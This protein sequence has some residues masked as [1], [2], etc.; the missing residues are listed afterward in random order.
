[1][2]HDGFLGNSNITVLYPD[3]PNYPC[4]KSNSVA[5]ELYCKGNTS[6]LCQKRLSVLC[7][8]SPSE[9]EMSAIA[10]IAEEIIA[11]GCVIVLPLNNKQHLNLAIQ[12]LSQNIRTILVLPSGIFGFKHDTALEKYKG[13]FTVLS[14]TAPG[15]EFTRYSYIN[16]LKFRSEIADAILYTSENLK[17]I[18]RDG[19]N[20]NQF[21]NLFYV[22]YWNEKRP[23]FSAISAKKIGIDPETKRPNVKLLL[24]CLN[25]CH[26]LIVSN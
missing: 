25:S 5:K 6:L 15:Q 14:Y 23:E 26:S 3:H 1:M 7:S 8:N 19:K 24:Q 16:S 20:L 11:Q 18:Q 4:T 22:N 13:C 10:Q 9:R 2:P 21:S 12:L 17:D